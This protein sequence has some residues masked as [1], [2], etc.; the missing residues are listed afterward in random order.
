M[1]NKTLLSLLVLSLTGP[2][3]IAAKGKIEFDEIKDSI[4]TLT[5]NASQSMLCEAFCVN[6]QML[7]L[8]SSNSILP[9]A[10]IS[11]GPVKLRTSKERRVLFFILIRP[12][13][14]H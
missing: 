1:K 8:I 2:M 5:Q 11:I 14:H 13:L 10:A 6:V 12:I 3:D 9:L 7:S 4:W